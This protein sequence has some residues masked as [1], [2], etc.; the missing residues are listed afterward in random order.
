[1]LVGLGAADGEQQALVGDTLDVTEGEAD[2][3]GAAE[4]GAEAQQQHGALAGTERQGR[5]G[6]VGEHQ[7][8]QAGHGGSGLAARPDAFRAGD[9]LED[10]GEA[11]MA[12]VDRAAGEQMRGADRGECD[13]DRADGKTLIGEADHVHGDGVGVGGERLARQCDA[14]GGV[15]LPG[16]AVGPPCAFAAGAGGV[17]RGAARELLELGSAGGA[18]GDRERTEQAAGSGAAGEGRGRRP[19]SV[20]AR[21]AS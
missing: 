12:E 19:A 1:M 16:R 17:D 13:T 7:A 10:H 2:E 5:G 3:L 15:V 4:R 20:A 11:G 18:V 21:D 6:A 8:Q 9:A 14:P